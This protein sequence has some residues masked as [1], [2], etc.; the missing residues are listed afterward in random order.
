MPGADPASPPALHT[1]PTLPSARRT[2]PLPVTRRSWCVLR[3]AHQGGRDAKDS[4]LPQPSLPGLCW[5]SETISSP[6]APPR[7]LDHSLTPRG[8][9][10]KAQQMCLP[11]LYPAS[12]LILRPALT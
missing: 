10:A 9:W 3:S 4:P 11:I 5:A 1:A 12:T 7:G 2:A 6:K 8:V